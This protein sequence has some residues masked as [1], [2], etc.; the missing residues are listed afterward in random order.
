LLHRRDGRGP[1]EILK[2]PIWMSNVQAH[3][4]DLSKKEVIVRSVKN[5]IDAESTD[6]VTI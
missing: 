3:P 4:S 1:V 2:L 6:I 5:W